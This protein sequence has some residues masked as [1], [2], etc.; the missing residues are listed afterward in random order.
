MKAPKKQE[1]TCQIRLN[2]SGKWTAGGHHP[3]KPATGTQGASLRQQA[4]SLRYSNRE[5]DDCV[6][7]PFFVEDRYEANPVV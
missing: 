7:L 2:L 3:E 4:E 5:A 6:C 1:R